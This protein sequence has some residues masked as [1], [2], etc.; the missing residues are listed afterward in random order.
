MNKF[1]T[2]WRIFVV[3]LSAVVVVA[4]LQLDPVAS[5]RLATGAGA[6]ATFG[7]SDTEELIRP[8]PVKTAD[9]NPSRLSVDREQDARRKADEVLAFFGVE[10]GMLVLDLYSGGG[11]YAELLSYIVGPTG[12][13][14]A[15][16]NS[17]NLMFAEDEVA[18]RYATGRLDN[19]EHWV[20]G[21]SRLKLS[22]NRYDVI[23]MIKVYHDVYFVSEET[24]WE[25]ID[26]PELLHEIFTAL[27]SG[28]VLGIVDHVADPGTRPETGGTLHRID[29][30][31]IKRDMAA[32][33][34]RFDGE[35]DI[36]RNPFDDRSQVV[37]AQ[38]VRGQTD[39]VVL[40]FRKP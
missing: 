21:N 1:I 17:S 5:E 18:A 23:I 36:L 37:F 24:G 2:A 29:P 31:L 35:I 6:S 10:S 27:K 38:S 4:C 40:R 19:V 12:R 33:G 3:C 28:G 39:R 30:A 11:Y 22:P 7:S 15:H 9:R 13:V 14:V 32:A 20:V 26:G 25:K 8:A 16:N 34:F